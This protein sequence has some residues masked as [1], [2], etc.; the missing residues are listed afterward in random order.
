MIIKILTLLLVIIIF[1]TIKYL[2]YK[3]TVDWYECT[4][5]FLRELPYTC[6]DCLQTHM[7]WL[8]YLSLSFIFNWNLTILI[9][10]LGLTLLNTIAIF[11]RKYQNKKN[12]E[13]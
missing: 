10:G 4:P 11:Y 13:I 3:I 8:T 12:N 7:M 5:T 9:A 2:A 1:F 6:G